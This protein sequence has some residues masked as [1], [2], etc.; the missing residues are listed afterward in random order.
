MSLVTN[1]T[2]I[3]ESRGRSGLR[4]RR[5]KG[6]THGGGVPTVR[7]SGKMG[8]AGFADPTVKTRRLQ[9]GQIVPVPGWAW[10]PDCMDNELSPPDGAVPIQHA[11]SPFRILDPVETPQKKCEGC[12]GARMIYV[13]KQ[14]DPYQSPRLQSPP[15]LD[16]SAI[17]CYTT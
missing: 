12:G 15:V 16:R 5:G 4:R 1:R 11:N 8:E 7:H 10:C 6:T 9:S 17:V 3:Q 2:Q 13:G 14:A